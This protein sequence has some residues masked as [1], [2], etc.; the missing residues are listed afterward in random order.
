MV[1]HGVSSGN[2][3]PW[4]S[5]IAGAVPVQLKDKACLRGFTGQWL[6]N[7]L[8]STQDQGESAEDK[9]THQQ[10]W[11][12]AFVGRGSSVSLI[13]SMSFS[14]LGKLCWFARIFSTRNRVASSMFTL[15]CNG[16]TEWGRSV[17][18]LTLEVDTECSKETRESCQ[19]ALGT[20][21]YWVTSSPTPV[22]V[23]CTKSPRHLFN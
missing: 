15:S 9:E 3:S 18:A 16:R 8:R 1:S 10:H 4:I 6:L 13:L 17:P 21:T 19:R 7:I 12:L 11:D 5:S 22:S 2:S 14:S 23:C 20:P